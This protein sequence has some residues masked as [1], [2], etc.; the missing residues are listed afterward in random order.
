[1]KPILTFVF[2]NEQLKKDFAAWMCDG[3]GEQEF[4]NTRP[5]VS[6]DYWQGRKF[7][8]NNV[9]EVSINKDEE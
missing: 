2:D 3:G 5:D 7:L 8:E 4:M 9:V 6:F 1:M